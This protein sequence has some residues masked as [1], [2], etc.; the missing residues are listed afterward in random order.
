MAALL[1]ELE[2]RIRQTGWR[3]P[4]SIRGM[5]AEHLKRN[6][7]DAKSRGQPA[8]LA[9]MICGFEATSKLITMAC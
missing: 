3:T 9:N 5:L 1:R 2:I 7:S 6:I 8:G 4:F